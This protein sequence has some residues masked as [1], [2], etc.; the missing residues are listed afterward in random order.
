[1]A[2]SVA[3]SGSTKPERYAEL[4]PQLAS[5]VDGEP[6]LVANLAN[7]SA[8]IRACVPIASWVG[9]YVARGGASRL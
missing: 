1:M 7:L 6:D 3:L 5:L 2:E 4:L 8:A 9:F